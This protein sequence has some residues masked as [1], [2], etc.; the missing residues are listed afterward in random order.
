MKIASSIREQQKNVHTCRI[1]AVLQRAKSG[2]PAATPAS[3]SDDRNLGDRK[4]GAVP[5][6]RPA[7]R[8]SDAHSRERS[9]R[10]ASPKRGRQES[11]R[12]TKSRAVQDD[13]RFI[14]E[15]DAKRVKP[16]VKKTVTG[17]DTNDPDWVNP[18]RADP[19]RVEE[20]FRQQEALRI[21][22]LKMGPQ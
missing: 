5:T 4:Q 1:Q 9:G 12:R 3:G 8:I 20:K 16:P 11:P 6:H 14:H 19:K 7:K 2:S 21:K 13:D 15:P 18:D 10:R 22:E 17:D